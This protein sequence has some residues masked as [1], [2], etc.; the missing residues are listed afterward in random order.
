MITKNSIRH[1]AVIL[2]A[3][4]VARRFSQARRLPRLSTSTLAPAAALFNPV[5]RYW[6]QPVIVGTT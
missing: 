2:F 5:P 4:V 6:A 3:L 1:F